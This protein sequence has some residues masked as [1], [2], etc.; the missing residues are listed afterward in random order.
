MDEDIQELIEEREVLIK[1][2]KKAKKRIVIIRNNNTPKILIEAE[3]KNL[4]DR[5][6]RLEEVERLIKEYQ[7]D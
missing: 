6:S 3:E 1:T 7:G 5:E 4:I 2:I